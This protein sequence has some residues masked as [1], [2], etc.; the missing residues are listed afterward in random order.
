MGR[1]NQ[2]CFHRIINNKRTFGAGKY[3]ASIHHSLKL[4]VV[5]GVF[6]TFIIRAFQNAERVVNVTVSAPTARTLP[7]A[8]HGD[9]LA[10]LFHKTL[11]HELLNHPSCRTCALLTHLLGIRLVVVTVSRQG[12]P[13]GGGTG[14]MENTITAHSGLE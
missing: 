9:I 5:C 8:R 3:S 13:Q 14:D 1:T 4:W 12:S 10:F 2:P 11:F 6:W 7:N